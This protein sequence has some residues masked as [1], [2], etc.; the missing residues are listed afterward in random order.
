M[1]A[2]VRPAGRYIR[3]DFLGPLVAS[4]PECMWYAALRE[5]PDPRG[6]GKKACISYRILVGA[7]GI[8]NPD[9]GKPGK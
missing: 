3:K 8:K 4:L 1:S 7:G 5:K 9:Q 2:R 6:C